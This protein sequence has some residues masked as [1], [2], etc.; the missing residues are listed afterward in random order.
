MKNKKKLNE[1]IHEG[2]EAL[3]HQNYNDAIQLFKQARA[4]A[5]G[6]SAARS[7]HYRAQVH[8]ALDQPDLSLLQ[9]INKT[10][11]LLCFHLT[12]PKN[13]A[14]R[15]K[16]CEKIWLLNPLNDR[17]THIL[18]QTAKRA[19]K[20]KFAV[21]ALH[22]RVSV[23]PNQSVWLIPLAQLAKESHQID[24]QVETLEQL[25]V[26]Q[27]E[28]KS[29]QEELEKAKQQ[30]DENQTKH[31][32]LLHT[33]KQL[34]SDPDNIDLRMEY[35]DGQ[36][37]VRKFDEAI[38]ELEAYLNTQ[39]SPSP[40]LEKRLFLAREHQINFKLAAAQDQHDTALIDSLRNEH[41]QLRIE[42]IKLQVERSP[43]D[44]QL[45]FDFG[46]V[47]YDCREWEQALAQFQHAIHHRQRRIRSLIYR[48]NILEK[49]DRHAEAKQELE[50]ALAELPE[51]TREKREVTKQLERLSL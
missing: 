27:G 5:P 38:S 12:S 40:R 9:K 14:N 43:N 26:L 44:L 17:G 6:N 19:N 29:I 20:T 42:Q 34:E 28:D 7:A 4:L 49:L 21:L 50:T 47:L 2:N 3:L 31:H 15:Y 33:K 25:L 13:S 35:L 36:L 24:I 18:I 23:Q 48:S 46:K 37:R 16:L 8:A 51:M 30:Q 45:R 41:D 1:K 39:S 10:W 22:A 32:P 11:L